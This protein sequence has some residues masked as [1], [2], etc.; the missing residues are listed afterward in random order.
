MSSTLLLRSPLSGLASKRR[1]QLLREP[2]VLLD[3]AR[4][5][6]LIAAER[7]DR[8]RDGDSQ[9]PRPDAVREQRAE[10]SRD[11]AHAEHRQIQ[12]QLAAQ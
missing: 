9:R 1:D 4:P 3:I 7:D 6:D 12:I 5:R 8:D 2:Q 11:Q 10:P